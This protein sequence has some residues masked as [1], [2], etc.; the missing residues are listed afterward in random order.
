M[1]APAVRAWV[2]W[3]SGETLKDGW[4]N[5][6]KGSALVAGPSFFPPWPADRRVG[7]RVREVVLALACRSMLAHEP[8]FF[9]RQVLGTHVVD[10]LWRSIRDPHTDCGELGRQLDTRKN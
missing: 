8:D 1:L 9:A 2:V 3:W 6:R 5:C 7:R 10:T 4:P